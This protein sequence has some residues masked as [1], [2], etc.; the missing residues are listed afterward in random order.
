LIWERRHGF[1]KKDL[2]AER[3]RREREREAMNCRES[4]EWRG[5]VGEQWERKGKRGRAGKG[6]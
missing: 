1:Y 6:E 5:K 2:Q 4:S 3:P